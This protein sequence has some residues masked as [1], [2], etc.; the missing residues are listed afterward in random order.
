MNCISSEGDQT[1][2]LTK[3]ITLDGELLGA[4]WNCTVHLKLKSALANLLQA[5]LGEG[6]GPFIAHLFLQFLLMKSCKA[7]NTKGSGYGPRGPEVF[8]HFN[9]CL[10]LHHTSSTPA[11]PVTETYSALGHGLPNHCLSKRACKYVCACAPTVCRIVCV[12]YVCKDLFA[13]M[14]ILLSICIH[15]CQEISGPEGRIWRLTFHPC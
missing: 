4:L 7:L 2:C 15:T 5:F 8:Q 13:H 3:T 6:L 12:E 10:W 11:V 9:T 14:Y 1:L